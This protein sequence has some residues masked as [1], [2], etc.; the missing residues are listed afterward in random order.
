MW[1]IPLAEQLQYTPS[2]MSSLSGKTGYPKVWYFCE[3]ATTAKLT[4]PFNNVLTHFDLLKGVGTLGDVRVDVASVLTGSV[5]CDYTIWVSAK[6]I[7]IQM[8]TGLPPISVTAQ[9]NLETPAPPPSR[10]KSLRQKNE[11]ADSGPVATMAST[12][13][14]VS[15]TLSKVPFVGPFAAAATPVFDAVGRVASFFGWSKPKDDKTPELVTQTQVRHMANFNG[16]SKVKVLAMDA[17]NATNIPTEVFGTDVD[18]MAIQEI[19]KRPIFY[20]YFEWNA[21]DAQNAIIGRIPVGPHVCTIISEAGPSPPAGDY[22]FNTYLSYLSKSFAFWR[23]S[24]EYTFKF[25]KTQYHSGRIRFF[26][27]PGATVS[28]NPTTIDFNKCYSEVHDIRVK[29]EVKFVVPFAYNMQW[30]EVG[31]TTG[32]VFMYVVNAL[33]APTTAAQD[34]EFLT[35]IN[36]GPDFQF[37]FPRSDGSKLIL[38]NADI[39]P[40]P[41][42]AIPVE[43]QSNIVSSSTPTNF[44][45]N[46]VAIGEAILS[47]RQILRRYAP[48]TRVNTT[49]GIY[50]STYQ[51]VPWAPNVANGDPVFTDAFC[52][53]GALYR[54]K[55]GPMVLMKSFDTVAAGTQTTYTVNIGNDGVSTSTFARPVACGW[56]TTEPQVEFQTP[57]YQQWPAIPTNIGG[58]SQGSGILTPTPVYSVV[59][60]N[61]GSDLISLDASEPSGIKMFRQA[62]EGFSFGCLIGPPV[63]FVPSS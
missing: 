38:S 61:V 21:A 39:P 1:F 6:N 16:D 19:V 27:V 11:N 48:Y 41:S 33:R 51:D 54:F 20:T 28:T 60:F 2:S 15:S 46:K 26:F 30:A 45:P 53:Y 47:L 29:N 55:S 36:A 40:P 25:V 13:G 56:T 24:L 9:S 34:I 23:G 63:T 44:S 59:P 5:D 3:D 31:Q 17:E 22:Y 7:D 50:Q 8:P 35:F 58:P 32:H 62:G 43:A 37:A 4:V 49:T 10:S 52:W 42:Y 14:G 57:F 12:L 18:E